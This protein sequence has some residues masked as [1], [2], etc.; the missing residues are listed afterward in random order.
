M[1][2]PFRPLNPPGPSVLD[3][4]P[5]RMVVRRESV[6]IH[7]DPIRVRTANAVPIWPV[8]MPRNVMVV[9]CR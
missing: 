4:Q 9:A 3:T 2:S 8:I 1:K 6:E 7:A 5:W